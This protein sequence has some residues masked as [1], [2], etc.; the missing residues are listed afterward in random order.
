MSAQW[1]LLLLQ[2]PRAQMS[3]DFWSLHLRFNRA[4]GL[5]LV[6]SWVGDTEHALSHA[7][8][9]F[10]EGGFTCLLSHP[11][12]TDGDGHLFPFARNVFTIRD[13]HPSTKVVAKGMWQVYSG[14]S[15]IA[16]TLRFSGDTIVFLHFCPQSVS[17]VHLLWGG[18]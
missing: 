2:S 4:S 14:A 1:Q 5:R 17:L 18:I 8:C 9:R 15:A 7:A 6:A 13:K 10:K 12:L 16:F 3:A 11:E